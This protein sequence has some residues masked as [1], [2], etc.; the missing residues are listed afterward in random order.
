[1]CDSRQ[2]TEGADSVPLNDQP[3]RSERAERGSRDRA[4]PA[5][6]SAPVPPRLFRVKVMDTEGPAWYIEVR[7]IGRNDAREQA[8]TKAEEQGADRPGVIAIEEVRPDRGR[9]SDEPS[10]NAI[11]RAS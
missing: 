7:A 4:Q 9:M 6:T 10:Y 11:E 8:R 2:P 5:R 3:E 1:M